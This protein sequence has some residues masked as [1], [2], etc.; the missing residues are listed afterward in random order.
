L[1]DGRKFRGPEGLA[2]ILK[3]DAALF[4]EALTEKMMTYAL[5]R[6]VERYD[7]PT[8]RK[9]SAAVA[10]KDHRFSALILEIINSTPFQQKRK[11]E[12]KS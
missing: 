11:E 9:I 1:P 2:S 8:I 5:G 4:T 3:G 6:G 12:P 10:A 7:R